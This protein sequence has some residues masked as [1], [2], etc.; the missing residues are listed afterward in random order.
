MTERELQEKYLM[1]FLCER[2]DGP[3]YTEVKSNMVTPDWFIVDDLRAFIRDTPPNKSAYR[4]L[5]RH[6][7]TEDA[8]M[9]ALLALL[10]ERIR[11][12]VNMAVFFNKNKSVTLAGVKLWLFHTSG[13]LTGG[14]KLFAQN[15]FSVVQE[16]PFSYP[17]EELPRFSFR[18]DL[19]F[20]LNGIY[21]GYSELKSTP[22]QQ[23]AK[24]HGRQKVV[25]DYRHAVTAYLDLAA[26]NDLDKSLRRDM[27]R[28]FEKAIHITATDVHDTFVLRNITRHF[29]TLQAEIASGRH[30]FDGYENELLQDFKVYPVR[31]ETTKSSA[32]FEEVFQALYAP[33]MMEKELLYYNFI[34]RVWVRKEGGQQ[35]EYRHSDGRLISPR[36]KQK[37]G[38]DKILARV[39][40][41]LEHEHDPDYFTR[42]LRSE[43]KARGFG[44]GR[45]EELI[46]KRQ[47]Y[48]NNKHVYSLLLQYAA[49]FGK[50]NIIGWTALQLKDLRAGK[51]HVFD[52][53]MLVTDRLQLRD[54]LDT[55]MHNMNIAKPMF[56]E[57]DSQKSFR[58][59]LTGDRRIVVVNLQKF[60]SVRAIFN[61]TTVKAMA[62]LRV[63]FLIDEVHRSNSGKLHEEMTFVFDELQNAF[64]SNKDYHERQTKKNLII[65]FTATPSDH[66]LARF[67]EFSRYA[68]S[69]KIWVPFDSYT[70][71]EAIRDG[72]ILNPMEGLVPVS[73]KMYYELPPALEQ[74][75][76]KDRAANEQQYRILKAKVYD[77][78]ERQI[79]IA[80]FVVDRLVKSVYHNI[81]G[82]AKAMLAVSSIKA[83]VSY[84]H[85]I[86]RLFAEV[87]REPKYEKYR[88]APVYV[89][90][91]GDAQKGYPKPSKL[92]GG[93]SEKKTLQDFAT[94][95]N[96]LI[97]VVDK[98]QTGFDEPRLHTL[99]LDKE[100]RGIN[101]IQTISRVNRTTKNKHDCKI[102][103]FSYRNVNVQNITEAFD[104][105]SNVVVS[106]FDPLHDADKLAEL[107]KTLKAHR[108]MKAHF[109][110]YERYEKG[111]KESYEPLRAMEDGFA[112]FVQKQ[113]VAA[114]A[115]KL[116][117]NRYFHILN[118]VEYVIELDE[119]FSDR[120]FLGFWRVFNEVFKR[121][122]PEDE[123]MDD[124]EIYFDNRIGIIAPSEAATVSTRQR[125][126]AEEDAEGSHGYR[127]NILAVIARRNQEE[128]AIED[129]ISAFE[130]KIARFF[131]YIRSD[132][133]GRRVVA[134][135]QAEGATFNEEEI[136]EDFARI[137]RKFVRRN[138]D[139]LGDFFIRETRDI[140]QQLC[141]DFERELKAPSADLE[142]TPTT[143]KPMNPNQNPMET[144]AF[145]VALVRG[146][147]Q[148]IDFWQNQRDRSKA[149]QAMKSVEE[150]ATQPEAIRQGQA[151]LNLAPQSTIDLLNQRIKTCQSRY[152]KVL[153]DDQG[154]LPDEVDAATEAVIRCIC[155][156]LRRL[157]KVN[158]H[159]PEGWM[160]E[161][162]DR[163]GC[164]DR[165]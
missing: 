55:K 139:E 85:H 94:C 144:A 109:A 57:A 87:T 123:V 69:E 108:L 12:S 49:G 35:K 142:N 124:V 16:L 154:Y 3:G 29:E 103:D 97:I 95:K 74:S 44:P 96:G 127:Y 71:S 56:T 155:R 21:L 131:S 8:L 93:L 75:L 114:H 125:P 52:K 113:A 149:V 145:V 119:A 82:Q 143:E 121:L 152:D 132:A 48:R 1:Q 136:Y 88:E 90:Y 17:Y 42:K 156:E 140:I 83:A 153:A 53:I 157:M 14:D 129:L 19:A 160:Q 112:A 40:E 61:D 81:R 25:T 41:L 34:E 120:H 118:R 111:E 28:P 65:G 101:A 66:T 45:I 47:Q 164:E 5:L 161:Y 102:I 22:K 146:T 51:G 46:E 4:K 141:D 91:T 64:D 126:E 73:A 54:Q 150:V 159:L 92:N 26:G 98:L 128:E 31:E 76:P 105:F 84:K 163:M 134:K 151:L 37:F 9:Q 43:M 133:A 86:D 162:W 106:D 116:S 117:V 147:M 18:P 39:E 100:I 70:M 122:Q 80:R 107:Y 130:K 79:A 158:G 24:Q 32:R 15:R 99:F 148:A 10:N 135:M 63:A 68:E 60:K 72:Y 67:G 110:G 30:R 137:Y 27:L 104:H 38:T 89:I 62:G 59:A 77:N 36:P 11:E 13:S 2:K 33:R 20:F 138:R 58:E 7:G 78:E 23:T 50:S 6:F 165:E 115:L